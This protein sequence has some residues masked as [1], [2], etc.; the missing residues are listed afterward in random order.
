[1]GK[2]QKT[3]TSILDI[4]ANSSIIEF[5]QHDQ[6]ILGNNMFTILRFTERSRRA[7]NYHG[8]TIRLPDDIRYIATDVDGNVHGYSDQQPPICDESGYWSGDCVYGDYVLLGKI[9]FKGNA[10]ASLLEIPVC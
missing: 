7:V 1:M 9:D 3:C 10:S 8:C 4:P 5:Q 2:R 6:P